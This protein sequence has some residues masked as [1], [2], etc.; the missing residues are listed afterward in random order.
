[1]IMITKLTNVIPEKNII[2]LSPHYDDV[3]L[4]FG[5]YLNS[6]VTNRLIKKKKIHII[7]IFS[8]SNYLTRDDEGNKDISV[9][10]VQHVTGIRLVE[11]ID[12]MNNLIGQENYSYEIEGENECLLRNKLPKFKGP[13]EFLSGDKDSFNEEDWLVYERLKREACK[14]LNVKDTAILLPL[15]VKEHIDHIV[16]REAV[17]DAKKELGINMHAVIYFGEDQPYTGLADKHDH[18]KAQAFLNELTLNSINYCI[19]EK[20]KSEMAMK[21]YPSQA[22]DSYREGV[23]KRS[24]QL[25]K[26]YGTD[27]GVERMY[28]LQN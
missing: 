17:M 15:G 5:G 6:L 2:I 23:L 13:I 10:R 3:L 4:V 1:M 28:R 16:I 12:C 21:Y 18:D 25:Q 14:W 7:S 27:T 11:E 24:L 22:E 26:K 20:R 8:F 9:T 19:D